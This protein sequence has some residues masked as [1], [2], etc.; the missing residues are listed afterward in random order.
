MRKILKVVAPVL[1]LAAGVGSVMVLAAAKEAPEKKEEA[2]RPISLYVDEVRSESVVLSVQTQGEVRPKTEI[3]LVPQVAGRIISIS[4]SFAEGAG[5]EPGEV[6]IQIEDA[7]YQLA[8]TSAEARL[9]EAKVKLEQEM[10]DARIKRKQWQDWV[11]DGEPTPLALNQPQVA[12]AQAKLRAAEADLDNAKLNLSRTRIKV[13]F[14]GRVL[15]RTAGVGQ[16]VTVGAKLGRVFA[17]DKVEV[18]LPLTDRQLTELNLPI[19]YVAS[20][21]KGPKVSLR[22]NLGGGDN[23]WEGRIVRTHASV[24]QQTRLMYAVAEVE[25]PYGQLNERGM[26]L[27]V[28]LFVTASIEGVTPQNALV[29]PRDALRSE[30]KVFV[31]KDEKL[32]IRTVDVL[33]TSTEQVFVT[34][35]VE[36]GEK[37]VTSP[38]RGAH[39]GMAA[40]PITR[41]AKN[42]IDSASR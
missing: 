17:T 22:A 35:G 26:P 10:A 20:A 21:G 32:E 38:V 29:M 24:D 23:V 15:E 9:A 40:V 42:D 37:V 25:D 11:K 33:S 13:P 5:F 12:E 16:Y 27:A 28:G 31:I 3:D 8:V 19:G 7:D 41:S 6:L 39:D 1:V 14:K 30:D 36:P 34:A 2:A 4:D 18:R